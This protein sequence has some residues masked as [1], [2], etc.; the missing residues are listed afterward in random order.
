MK[1][2]FPCPRKLRRADEYYCNQRRLGTK[3]A[4]NF[5]NRG[6]GEACLRWL[7][8]GREK[9]RGRIWKNSEPEEL[10]GWLELRPGT[11]VE[12]PSEGRIMKRVLQ[13]PPASFSFPAPEHPLVVSAKLQVDLLK[14]QD[15]WAGG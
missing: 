6:L 2:H 5:V 14:G 8:R 10:W 9:G 13:N 15:P 7:S 1:S 11:Q 4:Y 3:E 12:N